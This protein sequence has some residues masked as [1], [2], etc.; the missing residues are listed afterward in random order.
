V[1]R[2]YLEANSEKRLEQL[3]AAGTKLIQG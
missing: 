2:L 1:V 3:R